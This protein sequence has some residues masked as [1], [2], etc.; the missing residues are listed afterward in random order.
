[1]TTGTGLALLGVWGFAG[2]TS[3]SPY[4]SGF[5]TVVS[6]ITTIVLTRWLV[7]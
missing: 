2:A 6:W 5:F 1:M 7:P 3:A 4:T